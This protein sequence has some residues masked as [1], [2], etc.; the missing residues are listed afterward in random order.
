VTAVEQIRVKALLGLGLRAR[1][2]VVGVQQV[3]NAATKGQVALAIIA[4]DASAHS[5]AKV[6]PLLVARRVQ[7]IGGV[8]A[9][10]LGEVVG[11]EA[12]AAV[13]VVD[14]GLARG[15]RGAVASPATGPQNG[16]TG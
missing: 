15:I 8:T 5:K 14:A 1:T 2:V 16:G 6:V 12:T 11:R 4:D 3:R 7:V 9:A 13:A 10:W